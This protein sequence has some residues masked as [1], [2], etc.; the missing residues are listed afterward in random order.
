MSKLSSGGRFDGA[1]G[2]RDDGFRRVNGFTTRIHADRRG[3]HVPGHK[4]Y[5]P[6][7]SVLRLPI[8]E[9]QRLVEGY[10]GGG[11]WQEPNKEVIDFDR[12]IGTWVT[13]MAAIGPQRPVESFITARKGAISSP[14]VPLEKEQP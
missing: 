5:I 1:R 14:A 10:A 6:G 3:K 12:C 8:A 4:N 2:S 7:R 9:A 11:R 13:P